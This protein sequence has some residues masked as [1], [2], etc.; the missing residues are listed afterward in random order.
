MRFRRHMPPLETWRWTWKP[1]LPRMDRG[2]VWKGLA[3]CAGALIAGY[4]VAALILFPAPIFRSRHP[5]PRVLGMPRAD[6]VRE[7]EKAQLQVRDSGVE[8]HPTAP[9][10]TVVWQD[11]PPGVDAPTGTRV[12]VISSGGPSKVAVPDVTGYDAGM[13]QQILSAGGL[14]VA[15]LDSVQAPNTPPGL[16]VVTRP[17]SG[18]V[19]N[20]GTG[21][22]LVVN[23]GAPTIAVPDVV[24][25]TLTDA[26][27]KLEDAGLVVGA[28]MRRRTPGTN[29][30][31][32]IGQQPAAQTLASPG[33]VVDLVVAR[34]TE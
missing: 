4:L 14:T 8:F 20:P 11:P 18:T 1:R 10:G 29:P 9:A 34:A 3:A 23:R 19:A 27:T 5:V 2:R 24:G 16:V 28:V 31:T 32:V 22:V 33:L 30:G 12:T 21:V 7:L 15:R 26:R 25:L 13:A 6:A 17:P